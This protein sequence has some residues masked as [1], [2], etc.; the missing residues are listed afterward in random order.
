LS[1]SLLFLR[2]RIL[3]QIIL[4][5]HQLIF[6]YLTSVRSIFLCIWSFLK[7]LN[8]FTIHITLSSTYL[9]LKLLRIL[10]ILCNQYILLNLICSN[11]LLSTYSIWNCGLSW[12]WT[13]FELCFINFFI[14]YKLLNCKRRKLLIVLFLKIIWIY[15]RVVFIIKNL[16]N[17][18]IRHF[19]YCFNII[20]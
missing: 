9:C 14:L 16:M 20:Q 19:F 15:I 3:F 4:Y 8:I 5:L 18:F 2:F 1:Y 7:I 13:T 11:H 6:P 12:F 17:I 10:K